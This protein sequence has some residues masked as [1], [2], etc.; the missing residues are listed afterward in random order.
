[1]NNEAVLA[2][3]YREMIHEDKLKVGRTVKAPNYYFI[4][5][6]QKKFFIDA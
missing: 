1:M 6:G 3:A 2:D 4:V 5:Y